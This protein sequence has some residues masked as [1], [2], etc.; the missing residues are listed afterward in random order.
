MKNTIFFLLLLLGAAN[1]E[2][3]KPRLVTPVGHIGGLESIA[4]SPDGKYILTGSTDHTAKLWDLHGHEIQT[5]TGHTSGVN[6]VAFSPDGKRV[7]TGSR[8]ST[9]ILWDLSGK[10]IQTF[11]GHK[12]LI[13]SV[14]FS[15]DGN[16]I[17]TGSRDNKAM[18]WN[19]DGTLAQKF[20]GHDKDIN[21]VAFSPDGKLVLTSSK[22]STA[23]VWTLAGD[24]V[25]T[26]SGHAG[27]V[28]SAEFSPDGNFVLTSSDDNT[29]KLW[30]M[31]GQVVQ[32]FKGHANQ[33]NA[34]VFSPDGK[35]VLTGSHDLTARLWTLDGSVVKTFNSPIGTPKRTTVAFSPNGKQVLVGSKEGS[36][37]L[38]DLNG[39]ALQTFE[40]HSSGI[41]SAVF[42]PDGKYL[43]AG[44]VDGTTKVWDPGARSLRTHHGH[45]GWVTAVAFSA[46]ADGQQILT[47]SKDYT[48]KLWDLRG[49]KHQTFDHPEEVASVVFSTSDG[50]KHILIGGGSQAKLWSWDG[51]QILDFTYDEAIVNAVAFLNTDGKK[52]VLT[53][54]GTEAKLWN[55]D[56]QVTQT[57]SG[58][59][60]WITA[61]APSPDGTR[62]LTG[63]DDHTAKLW[64][65]DGEVAQTFAG[66]SKGISSVAFSPD[67][68]R[69]LTGSFDHT[70]KLWDLNGRTVHTFSGHTQ[71]VYSAVFSADGKFVLTASLD[72]TLK[73]WDAATG[74]ERATLM[75]IDSQDW[76]VTTPSGLFDASPGAMSRMHFVVGLEV[77]ELEQLK[78]RY[79][80]PALL[81]KIM[82]LNQEAPRSVE[83]FREV[84]LYP[85][86]DAHLNTERGIVVVNLTAR[87]GGIGR[88]NLLVNG[89]E[90]QEDANPDRASTVTINLHE[91]TRFY[92]PDTLNQL[93]LRVYNSAGWLKSRPLDVHFMRPVLPEGVKGGR[94]PVLRKGPSLFAVV[95]GTRDYAG[96]A[97]DLQFSDR[98]ATS[99]S[100][101]LRVAASKVFGDRVHITLLN[102]DDQ[103]STRQG[104]SSK[105][106]I[107]QAFEDIAQEAQPQDVLLIYCSGHGVSYGPAEQAQFH[108][109]TKDIASENLSDPEI[110]KNFT[111]SSSEFTE[112]VNAIAA[113]KQVLILDAC[114][115]GKIVQD[116]AAG[117]KDLS[118]SQ[119]RALD[120]MKDRTGMF[121]LT[122]SAADKVSYEANE[123]GQGLLTYTLLQ[124]MRGLALT[125][126][127]RVDVMKLF[128]HARDQ[129]PELAKGINGIQTPV[130]AFPATGASFDIGIVDEPGKIPLAEK[131]PV[132]VRNTFQDDDT[133]DD[134]LGLTQTIADYF[135]LLTVKGAQAELLYVDVVEYENA[136]S[137][138]GRYTI[139][140]DDVEVRGRL[141]QGKAS[142]G[143]FK[144]AG[145]KSDIPALVEAILDEVMGLM[146]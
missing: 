119:I 127:N 5:F 36:A 37:T 73:L 136:Y 7:L 144:V 42:S 89:K 113:L 68:K 55:M 71:E 130:L 18:L 30:S 21:S 83:A 125:D 99:I 76:V 111:V 26:F 74:Q 45:T 51:E 120:R 11:A 108:Y 65:L 19:L 124:G 85:Q 28:K 35:Y 122:G 112:W 131:K 59:K 98:D 75:A 6:S 2:A 82:G 41:C 133:F 118:A 145:K 48:A 38:W 126:D 101:A 78:E 96:D 87:S 47:G 95:V 43:L 24:V 15:P 17:L 115:S 123:Y 34:A 121:I 138:K 3:Q 8:D 90:V 22:D 25:Q 52:Q 140:G 62:V 32:T 77:V 134:V 1:L 80:E 69:L 4:F 81:A 137:M 109:L 27:K 105:A 143:E 72:N 56:G 10:V 110:R 61:V 63:S 107:R 46:A 67:G 12:K 92:L 93:A 31:D 58:H 116:L 23:K 102:T 54:S 104:V 53:G 40:G 100:R 129:V 128:Q 79:F 106:N 86:M 16:Q 88:L 114:N 60:K 91:F 64:N 33:V 141:F 97:L 117:S 103:D 50:G 49:R 44:S 39:K 29:A 66:H 9:V 20:K 146:E 139:K 142:K 14:A 57:F 84:A 135:R 13:E 94:A 132:F 70:A